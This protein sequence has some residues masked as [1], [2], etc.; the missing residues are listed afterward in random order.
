MST[1][2]APHSVASVGRLVFVLRIYIPSVSSAP[3][4]VVIRCAFAGMTTSFNLCA[5]VTFSEAVFIAIRFIGTSSFILHSKAITGTGPFGFTR[6]EY[7]SRV[8]CLN[9]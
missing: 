1:E 9:T 2:V 7:V 3:H 6:T 4:W 5:T 8:L